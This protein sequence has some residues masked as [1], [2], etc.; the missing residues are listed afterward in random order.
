MTPSAT[1]PLPGISAA[2]SPAF[3]AAIAMSEELRR[4]EDECSRVTREMSEE[5]RITREQLAA[6]RKA[7]YAE[8]AYAVGGGPLRIL[9]RHLLPATAGHLI[10]ASGQPG[11]ERGRPNCPRTSMRSP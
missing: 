4:G 2:N 6:E 8:A 10:S 9:L 5:Q 3:I 1:A 11:R 7:P